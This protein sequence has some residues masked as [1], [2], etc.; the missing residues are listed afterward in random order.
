MAE[1]NAFETRTKGRIAPSPSFLSCNVCNSD[2]HNTLEFYVR[3]YSETNAQGRAKCLKKCIEIQT[4][5]TSTK[6]YLI[7]SAITIAKEVF[8]YK[9][10]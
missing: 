4:Q 3:E 8:K 10:K 7:T 6:M 9:I 2:I 1:R 5:N